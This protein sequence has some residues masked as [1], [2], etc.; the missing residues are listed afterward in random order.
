MAPPRQLLELQGETAAAHC[1]AISKAFN[2]TLLSAST[3]K[4]CGGAG[5]CERANEQMVSTNMHTPTCTECS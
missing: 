4:R 2:S 3:D 5:G 1:T